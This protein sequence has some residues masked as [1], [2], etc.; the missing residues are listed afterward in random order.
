MFTATR[1]S[2]SCPFFLLINM[3]IGKRSRNECHMHKSP[4]STSSLRCLS[5]SFAL[6]RRS[7]AHGLFNLCK[8]YY[9]LDL[10]HTIKSLS[11]CNSPLIRMCVCV[12]V[13]VCRN[14]CYLSNFLLSASAVPCL[15]ISLLLLLWLR[16]LFT[17][18]HVCSRSNSGLR[19]CD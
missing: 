19:N 11:K 7:Q 9:N 17:Y 5:L 18:Y 15:F 10:K 16:V 12:R 1:R 13:S 3:C 8:I 2:I 4:I 14:S 6:S